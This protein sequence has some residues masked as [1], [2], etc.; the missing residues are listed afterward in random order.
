MAKI[1]SSVL[2]WLLFHVI[3]T[4]GLIPIQNESS[5]SNQVST[6][7]SETTA[8]RPVEMNVVPILNTF[9]VDSNT[10]N[11]QTFLNDEN[12]LN[13]IYNKSPKLN[14]QKFSLN[15]ESIF[16]STTEIPG[17]YSI[18]TYDSEIKDDI[19]YLFYETLFAP[20]SS[21]SLERVM[22]NSFGEVLY[23]EFMG[24]GSKY[25]YPNIS[26]INDTTLFGVW[27]NDDDK[28]VT[29]PFD[30]SYQVLGNPY[31]LLSYQNDPEME[32]ESHVNLA[33][34]EN[35]NL[36]MTTWYDSRSEDLPYNIMGH[37][38][39]ENRESIGPSFIINSPHQSFYPL[40]SDPSKSLFVYGDSFIYPY[41]IRNTDVSK[42]ELYLA[43]LS[44]DDGQVI[45]NSIFVTQLDSIHFSYSFRFA[46]NENGYGIIMWDKTDY[47]FPVLYS[48][49]I[50]GILI[51][52]GLEVQQGILDF[53]DNDSIPKFKFV[54]S[55][56]MNTNYATFT[57][58]DVDDI[59][60]GIN[61]LKTGV[62]VIDSLFTSMNAITPTMPELFSLSTYPNPFNNNLMI[63][64][65]VAK[66]DLFRIRIVNILGEEVYSFSNTNFIEGSHSLLWDG[67]D[68]NG[69]YLPSGVYF[70][71]VNSNHQV[72]VEKVTF[73][74]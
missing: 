69:K 4:A 59:N 36:L 51:E 47:E 54:S 49:S 61:A 50:S 16:D 28:L 42:W 63:N 43:K 41:M 6:K 65:S 64:I 26:I 73:L 24:W 5:H 23:H 3:L 15:G 66:A 10:I 29:Q 35:N 1:K 58:I 48:S 74:K 68:I 46:F 44:Y 40:S 27:I 18:A 20:I 53:V 25:Y 12:I 7:G 70:I 13:V 60:E 67:I 2:Y 21:W 38:F 19:I 30:L 11:A 62:I 22:I 17:E 14:Y 34:N 9:E 37:L 31:I 57:Y 33:H 55:V 45:N 56:A 8:G 71:V 32:I 52:P 39:N 72:H